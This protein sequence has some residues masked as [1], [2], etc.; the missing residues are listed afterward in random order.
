MWVK[1]AIELDKSNNKL[2]K[3]EAICNSKVYAKELDSSYLL[4]FYYLV[5]W[6]NY[7]KKENI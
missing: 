5:W 1:T 4:A 3:F 7:L 6:K 2:Y